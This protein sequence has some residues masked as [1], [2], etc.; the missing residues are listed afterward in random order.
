MAFEKRTAHSVAELLRLGDEACGAAL[1]K[2]R[3]VDLVVSSGLWRDRRKLML[4]S[5][6]PMG[7][8]VQT[9]DEWVGDAWDLYGDGRRIVT[10]AQRRIL[11][12]PLVSRVGLLDGAPSAGLVAQLGD[13]AAEAVAPGLGPVD[14]L[15]EAQEKVI[16]IVRAYGSELEE[17]GLVEQAQLEPL[18]VGAMSGERAVVL[19]NADLTS[20]HR[21]KFAHELSERLSVVEIERGLAIG[22]SADAPREQAGELGELRRALY[23]GSGALRS[24]GAVSVGEAHGLHASDAV[25]CMLVE[26]LLDA[27]EE[28]EGISVVFPDAADSYPHTQEALARAGI[29]FRARFSLPASRTPLGAAFANLASLKQDPESD[30]SYDRLVG[31]IATPYAGIGG[32]DARALQMRWRERG[33]STPAERL[34]DITE[35]FA[36]GNADAGVTKE[37][38]APLAELLSS[39]YAACVSKMFSHAAARGSDEDALYDDRAAASAILGHIS[40]C[41]ELGRTPDVEDLA[42][43]PVSLERSFGDPDNAVDIIGASSLLAA[44]ADCV[45]MAELDALHYPMARQAGPFDVL[46]ESLGLGVPDDTVFRQRILLQDVIESAGRKIAFSRSTRDALGNESVQSALWDE[47]MTVYRGERDELDDLPVQEIPSELRPHAVRISEADL[48]ARGREAVRRT[49]NVPRGCLENA[50]EV[51]LLARDLSGKETPF[52]PTAIEDYYRCP[53]RWFACRRVGYNGMDNEFD[54]AAQGNLAHA[55]LERFYRNLKKRGMERVTP[56][57]LD[58]ALA[59]ASG[60]LDEQVAHDEGRNRGGIFIRTAR[61]RYEI[62]EI[63]KMLLAL[64]RRDATFLPGYV[65]TYFEL[66]LGKGTGTMLSYG[67]VPVRGKVD[68]IDVDGEGNAVIVDYKL[69]GLSRGYGLDPDRDVPGRIQTD[70]YARLVQRHFDLLG[71]PLHVV[72]SVYRSYSKNCLRGAYSRS[73]DWGEGERVFRDKDALPRSG[74]DETYDEYL[75]L[76]E[77]TVS[78]CM[79]RL[80]EG[81]IEPDPLD[82]DTKD[83]CEFCKA[84]AFCPRGES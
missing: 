61:D 29:P 2:G 10:P 14:G 52:S 19:E 59:V 6:Y 26:H 23:T 63:R 13:F 12:R 56:G 25:I 35:G 82:G 31:L 32:K 76:V 45:V 33:G 80:H 40:A 44:P 22:I 81:H 39:D 27:G 5:I 34:E 68:R 24:T 55:S 72:G 83:V 37:R 50:D 66:T 16:E 74:R 73:I 38:L 28:P 67:G 30:D 48:F 36:Q 18:L 77:R 43:L 9:Y 65:P 20:P 64:V 78:S 54:A 75:D 41:E 21:R 17:R 15:D 47:V 42:K 58:E 11:L 79:E 49:W 51:D 53:Y 1:E 7:I 57:N 69:S 62:E 84:L 4:R 71:V 3:A 60:A 46:L 8:H 70:I